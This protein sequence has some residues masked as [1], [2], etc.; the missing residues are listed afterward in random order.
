M[1]LTAYAGCLDSGTIR[2]SRFGNHVSEICNLYK[3]GIGGELF[4][5]TFTTATLEA[6][7]G[8]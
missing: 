5:V 2:Q 3:Y 1:N 6:L 7:S 4:L 8:F